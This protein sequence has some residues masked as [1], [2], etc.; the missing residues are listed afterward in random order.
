[1]VNICDS[2]YVI[3]RWR[4]NE[5]TQTVWE[6]SGKRLVSDVLQCVLTVERKFHTLDHDFLSSGVVSW[7]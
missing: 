5:E 4:V 7:N 3:L 1:M 6:I 2:M